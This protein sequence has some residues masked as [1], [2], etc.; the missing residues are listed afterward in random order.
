MKFRSKLYKSAFPGKINVPSIECINPDTFYAFT[1]T[2]SQQFQFKDEGVRIP[3]FVNHMKEIFHKIF[4]MNNIKYKVYLEISTKSQNY[5][6][7]GLVKFMN[8]NNILNFYDQLPQYN[9]DY[10][11]E[12]D[13]IEHMYM[14]YVYCHKQKHIIKPICH[15]YMVEYSLKTKKQLLK[16]KKTTEKLNL[17]V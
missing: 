4:V 2:P 6:Y 11:I 9:D 1:I 3:K 14:W 13:S 12:I 10:Q 15:H 17:A 16:E 7:H 5:H 8:Y